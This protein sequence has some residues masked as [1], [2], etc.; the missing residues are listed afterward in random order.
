MQKPNIILPAE[1]AAQ[2]GVMLTWPHEG[3]DWA[4]MLD[5]VEICFLAIAKAISDR[6]KLLI[7]CKDIP[8]LTDKLKNCRTENIVFAAYPLNDT[9]ARDHGAI[10]VMKE[11]K[12][13]L[14]DFTFNGWGM[15]FA[16]NFDNQITSS[17]YK[18]GFFRKGVQYENLQHFVLEGGSLESD[19]EGTLLTTRDCLLSINRN[20]H[21]TEAAIEKQLI[22]L[23][24]LQQMLWLSSGYLAGDDTDSHIDTLARFCDP[25]TIA[26]VKCDDANDE[27]F[28]ALNRM[29]QELTAFRT[30][31]NQAYQLIPLPMADPVF[32]GKERL[33]ATY[34]NFL[35]IN[36]AVLVPFYNSPKDQIAAQI[37]QKAFPDREII[38]IDC[39]PLIIQHG[40]LHCVTM[41]F[42]EGVL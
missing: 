31:K 1:W 12:P 36:G 4:D 42:P 25:Q 32:D 33:P 37:L 22:D 6:E 11:G 19:G 29:E 28:E 24:G 30:L 14:Y 18:N 13:T 27:H 8:R 21:L 9:W 3:T 17:L 7:V 35:I 41:Q 16:A 2:C 23:F 10:T 5:E 39:S 38:G 34:A 40:S 20:Q 15:K 26:Y